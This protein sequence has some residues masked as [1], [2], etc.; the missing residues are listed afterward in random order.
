MYINKLKELIFEHGENEGFTDME[1]YYESSNNFSCKVFKGE[2]DDYSVSREGGI[3]FRGIYNG[4][5][6]YSYTEKIDEGV[7]KVLVK[8]AKEN[9][10]T[11]ENEDEEIIFKGS[12]EYG[13]IDLYSDSLAEVSIDRKLDLVKEL[14]KEAYSIDERVTNVN[15]CMY[16]DYENERRLYNTKGL[17]K[18]E[19]SNIALSYIS[20]VVQ[21]NND[22]QNAVAFKIG[23]DFRDFDVKS[24]AKEAVD[25]AL[26]YL[27]A[28]P[29]ESKTYTI[30][31][32]NI[33]SANLLK[34]FA[35]V[36]SAD[37]VQKGR[38]LLKD[39]L[40]EAIGSMS[41]T[42]IDDPFMIGGA[43]CRSFDSEGVASEK[44][45]LIEEGILQSLLHNLKTAKKDG[46]E[47]TGHGYRTSYKGAITVEPSNLYIQPGLNTYED[48]VSSM[49]EGLIITELQG[50]HSGANTISG[51]FSLAAKGYYVEDGVI[52]RAVNQITIAGNFYEVL[53]NI[54]VIGEDLVFAMPDITYIGSPSLKIKDIAV[55]GE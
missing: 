35:D 50:L 48:M 14:E 10:K 40:G 11:I 46:I 51:D 30:L 24:L 52:K 5:M 32:D 4:Q 25:K 54:E 38:S 26:S 31:L 12:K 36:F 44:I 22:I 3:S 2:I 19:K 21:E 49:D 45:S 39:K 15:Y 23:H 7:A 27:G 13:D 33:A 18:D 55:S 17:N 34:T 29:V 37:N 20:A 41:L 53:K 42:I 6:G 28:K 1:V 9:A 47:S 16:N 8:M 43:A